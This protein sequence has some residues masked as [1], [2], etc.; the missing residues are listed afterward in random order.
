MACPI[1]GRPFEERKKQTVILVH[2]LVKTLL[3]NSPNATQCTQSP[4]DDAKFETDH[5]PSEM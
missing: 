2:N 5:S 4:C 3:R 1:Y